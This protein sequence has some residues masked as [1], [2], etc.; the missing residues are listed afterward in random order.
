MTG[1]IQK[2]ALI[3]YVFLCIYLF[4][5]P[6]PQKLTDR[7]QVMDQRLQMNNAVG[8]NQA[9]AL[10]LEMQANAVD[11]FLAEHNSRPSGLVFT[12]LL[13]KCG[14]SAGQEDPAAA[15]L[16]G[17]ISM[18]DALAYFDSVEHQVTDHLAKAAV[19]TAQAKPEAPARKE[20]FLKSARNGIHAALSFRSRP[21]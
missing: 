19:M 7:A 16:G 5:K 1:G 20:N 11:C 6:S 2:W 15:V 8:L 10:A 4:A 17:G 18:D 14:R 3:A 13:A 21:D 12:K 9:L